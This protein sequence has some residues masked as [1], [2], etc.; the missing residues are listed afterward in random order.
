MKMMVGAS[1]E[2]RLNIADTILLDSPNLR[3]GIHNQAST[4]Q[5]LP[6]SH[7]DRSVRQTAASEV[8]WLTVRNAGGMAKA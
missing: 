6:R 3:A 2:A 7:R 1:F 5:R 8:T 4:T